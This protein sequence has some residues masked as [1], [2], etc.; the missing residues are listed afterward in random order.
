MPEEDQMLRL[1][2]TGVAFFGLLAQG[3]PSTPGGQ[4]KLCD[5]AVTMGQMMFDTVKSQGIWP[6]VKET[7][8][9]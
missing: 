9:P 1:N 2:A 8:E 5:K 3:A 6:I 7:N 4:Q